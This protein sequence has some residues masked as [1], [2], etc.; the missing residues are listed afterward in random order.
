VSLLELL[1]QV[2]RHAPL[3][4]A[5]GGDLALALELP[6]GPRDAR[7]IGSAFAATLRVHP[8]LRA[9]SR[10]Y[11]RRRHP[12]MT[13]A[14]AVRGRVDEALRLGAPKERGQKSVRWQVDARY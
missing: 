1:E 14:R 10:R 4:G 7:G 12:R 6:K 9:P 13:S 5:L 11:V 8:P 2:G 3:P